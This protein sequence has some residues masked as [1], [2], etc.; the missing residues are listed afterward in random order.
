MSGCV[1]CCEGK[2]LTAR[3]CSVRPLRFMARTSAFRQG[4]LVLGDQGFRSASTFLSAMLVGRA[5]GQVEYGFYT[6]LL[7]VLVSAE[8]FQA[9]LVTTPYVVQSPSRAAKDKDIYLGSTILIQLLI[10]A[11]TSVC[12]LGALYA[13]PLSGSGDLS[14]WILPAFALA[15]FAVL[16]REFFR[17]VLLADLEVGWNLVFGAAVH[18]SLILVLLGLVLAGGLNAWTAY[19]SIAGCSLVPALAVLGSRRHR[20]RFQIQ[21][22]WRQL[23]DNWRVGRWLVAQAAIMIISGPVY[24]WVLASSRG[25]AAVGLLGAC[26]L[27][28][29]LMSPLAQALHAFLL[30]KTSHAVQRGIHHVR[31]I[32]LLSSITVGLALSIF[33]IILGLFSSTIMDVLFA[34]KYSPSGWLVLFFA[35]RTYVVV[36]FVPLQAGLIACRQTYATFKSEMI[37]LILTAFIGLPLTCILGVWGVAWGFLLTRLLSKLYLMLVFRQYMKSSLDAAPAAEVMDVSPPDSLPVAHA[38]S[39]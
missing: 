17:Q 9:A 7:T 8:A 21:D 14:P 2:R 36:T 10:A 1:S 38:T 22:L 35:L 16:F 3:V 32:V 37:S 26:L 11:S 23:R 20:I 33:P 30:P 13:F 27:P 24:S 15:Y 29:S 5:C 18:G 39:L 19:A 4:L 12:L 28:S 34:G 25:A 31:R 6:L